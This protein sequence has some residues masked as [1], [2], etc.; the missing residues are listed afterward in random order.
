MYLSLTEL[1]RKIELTQLFKEVFPKE[2]V[3]KMEGDLIDSAEALQLLAAS[4][5]AKTSRDRMRWKIRVRHHLLLGSSCQ[6]QNQFLDERAS[7]GEDPNWFFENEQE[8]DLKPLHKFTSL[9]EVQEHC[10][11][12]IESDLQH[13]SRFQHGAASTEIYGQFQDFVQQA[14]ATKDEE[15]LFCLLKRILQ[16]RVEYEKSDE[17]TPEQ[18]I[19][20]ATTLEKLQIAFPSERFNYEVLERLQSSLA[21]RYFDLQREESD[22]QN[23][24]VFHSE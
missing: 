24:T 9:A 17:L 1:L 16:L 8:A 7:H 3:T 20:Q 11:A 18:R 5:S 15:N 23:C 4:P 10:R 22:P 19:H 2:A 12:S 6:E 13:V 14:T 21:K